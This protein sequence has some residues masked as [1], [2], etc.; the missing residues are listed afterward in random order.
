MSVAPARFFPRLRR[1]VFASICMAGCVIPTLRAADA[2]WDQ[3]KTHVQPFLKT[4]CYECHG[5]EEPENGFR[6]DQYS[7][8]AAIVKDRKGIEEIFD[9]LSHQEMPPKEKRRPAPAEFAAV[10]AWFESHL[11]VDCTGPRDPGRVTLRRLNRAEYNNTLHDLLGIDFRP[12]DA[13]PADVAGYGFDNNGDVLSMAPV[14]ME[15]YL[16]A[17]RLSLDKAI[18]TDPIVPPPSQRWEAATLEGT[19]AKTDPNAAVAASGPNFGAGLRR[20]SPVGRVFPERGEIFV[21][22]DFPADGEYVLRLRAYGTQGSANRARPQ[23]AFKIDDLPMDAPFTIKE[24]QRNTSVYSLK[25]VRVTAGKHRVAL[26]FLNGPSSE[27]V[28]AAKAAAEVAAAAAPAGT[29]APA[30]TAQVAAVGNNEDNP[31]GDAP[32]RRAREARVVTP[33]PVD[34]AVEAAAEAGAVAPKSATPAAATPAAD[35]PRRPQA[36][37]RPAAVAT[38]AGSPTGKPT[39][40]VIY[41]EAEGPLAP[42]PDRMPESYRRVMIA[43]PSATVSKPEA[44]EKILRSFARK[45]FRR[46][47]RDDE[48]KQL[49]AFWTKADA[50]GRSF[51]DS[52][53]LTLQTVLA[54]PQFL[55]RVE[56]EPQANELDGIHTLNDH[57]LATRLSYFLWSTTPDAE[58]SALADAGKLRASLATQVQRMMKDP[59]SHSLI[60]NFAGQWLQLR[61]MQNVSPDLK[62]FPQFDQQLR[63]AMTKETEL[64]FNAIMQE[65]RSVLDFLDA[66]FTFL[67]ERL[68]Q[69]YSIAGVKGEEF[70]RVQLTDQHRGGILTHASV[71][72]ITSYPSR[73]SPVQRGKWVLENLLDDAP[74]PPPPNVPALDEAGKVLSGTLRQRMEQHRSNSQ[75]ASC[76]S[77][78]DPIGFGLENY[79]AIGAWRTKDQDGSEIDASSTLPDGRKIAGAEDLK[80]ILRGQQDRFARSLADRMLTFALGR[81][82]EASDNCV[83]D[84]IVHALKQ[85]DYKFS[86]LVNEIV[87]SDPFQ[88]RSGKVAKKGD[89]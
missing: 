58:L 87:N 47:V 44:A 12:A 57:E 70:R 50:D 8:L 6:L 32:A 63:T 71:L 24:D 54:S 51:D 56:L 86:V 48:L 18:K 89:L 61:Q 76:H 68:A 75:C 28:A 59:R 40:G 88:K 16:A 39:L 2:E 53:H 85:N 72:T 26:A 10:M 13:F 46:P 80:E 84:E 35:P 78:M 64:F 81:G 74:P 4:H 55:F 25:K 9:K 41:L 17:A 52:I 36:A 82:L 77:R 38:P 27:E 67:N 14:L 43:Q 49:L 1:A 15:K 37:Q 30:P 66:D 62:L 69:H 11:Q 22:Y 3:F 65:N 45:A 29:A 21:D 83:V 20:T 31:A 19:F 7:N 5:E 73:T 79:D 33:P 23:V 60:E 42:T 34:D